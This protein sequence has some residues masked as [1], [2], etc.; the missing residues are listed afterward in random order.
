MRLR[1]IAFVAKELDPVAEDIS[2]V[3][4]LEVCFNDPGVGKF[5][6]HNALWPIAGNF[7]EV[8]APTRDGTTAGRYLDRRQGD[9]GYMLLFDCDDADAHRARLEA[10]GVRKVWT[11]PETDVVA[12]HFHPA[13]IPGCI[14]S[15]DTMLPRGDWHQE[16]AP[17]K[18]AG[19]NW[20]PHVRTD[21][22][23]A[24]TAVEIQADNH[25]AVARRWAELFELPIRRNAAGDP[26][27]EFD[28]IPVRFVPDRDGQGLGF[29]GIDVLPQN[30][31]AILEAAE[32]RKLRRSDQQ[33]ELCGVRVN[34]I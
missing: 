24:L 20:K 14:V 29:G 6:L 3:L 12:N 1:Q 16:M 34:L 18:W 28:N 30:R 10:M 26:Q 9:G 31:S 21:R 2:D 32:R 11:S 15:I 23:Q 33:I 27:V 4:G 17:W 5:G 7:I 25:E 19:P 8:V 22:T 13:D